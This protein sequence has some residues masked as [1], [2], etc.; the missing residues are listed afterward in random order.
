MSRICRVNMLI[1]IDIWIVTR[2]CVHSSTA[3]AAGYRAKVA[4]HSP[5]GINWTVGIVEN[6]EVE[7]TCGPVGQVDWYSRHMF[8]PFAHNSRTTFEIK[9]ICNSFYTSSSSS[10]GSEERQRG[11]GWVNM[12]KKLKKQTQIPAR[13]LFAPRQSAPCWLRDETFNF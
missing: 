13:H 3:E 7:Y 5:L 9:L 4:S 6:F 8:A 12:W 2:V 11:C 1:E 10:A